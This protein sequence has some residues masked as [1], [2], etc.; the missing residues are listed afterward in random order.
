MCEP[1]CKKRVYYIAVAISFAR[2]ITGAMTI[3][4]SAVTLLIIT[5]FATIPLNPNHVELPPVVLQGMWQPGVDCY[6]E[7]SEWG[8]V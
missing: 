3:S 1:R 2:T 4:I 8:G 5:M 6:L 7:N